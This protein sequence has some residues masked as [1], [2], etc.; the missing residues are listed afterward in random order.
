[1]VRRRLFDDLLA[2]LSKKEYSILT[3]ARQTGK[4]TLLKQL[5][6]HCNA[7]GISCVFINLENKA[8]LNDLND[9]PLNLLKYL[10][11]SDNR[12]VAFI[13]EVQYLRDASNFLKHLYDDH[14]DQ[15]KIV[16]TGSSAFYIDDHFR[17]SL[18]GR[19]KIFQLYTCSFSEYLELSGKADLVKE[20]ERIVLNKEAKSTKID[21]LRNEWEEYMTY[22]GYPAV[23]TE[24]NINDKIDRLKEI[25]DSFVKRDMLE[26]RVENEE[27]FY[28]LFRILAGQTGDLVNINE[29]SNTLRIRSETVESYLTIM[30]KC[31][32]ITLIRPFFKNL[33]KELVKMPKVFVMDMGL[34]NCLLN[35]FQPVNLRQDKG[36]LWENLY[37]RILTDKYGVDAIRFWRTADKHEVDFVIQ[38]VETPIAIEVKFDEKAIKPNKYKIF[39]EAYPEIPLYFAWMSPFNEDFFRRLKG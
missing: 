15:L 31:F 22:G 10:P 16:A 37:F 7:T 12:V 23:V 33:R 1:M 17:D 26:S 19:K 8:I 21:Y 18:A 39:Q 38:D 5:E 13:D 14:A 4:S 25:R 36:D 35:N 28:N 27:A 30:R 29:L 3:G 11:S 2:H 34:R 6:A 20:K 32:H 24:N 9:T